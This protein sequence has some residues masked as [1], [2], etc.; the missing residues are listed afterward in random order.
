MS[1]T[2]AGSEH[3]N[4]P[5]TAS[6]VASVNS[7]TQIIPKETLTELGGIGDELQWSEQ[8]PDQPGIPSGFQQLSNV[9]FLDVR[10]TL[11]SREKCCGAG[12]NWN[13]LNG[14]GELVYTVSEDT[15]MFCRHLCGPHRSMFLSVMNEKG[16]IVALFVKPWRC[17]AGWVPC[18]M[19]KIMLQTPEDHHLG[20]V[21]QRFSCGDAIMDIKD[22]NDETAFQIKGGPTFAFRCSTS[23]LYGIYAEESDGAEG[24]IQKYNNPV[25]EE[26]PLNMS[27]EDFM[28]R[29]PE[30]A[31]EKE[32]MLIIGAA[33]QLNFMY[34][35]IT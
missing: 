13:L 10:T 35:E 9:D 25:L 19:Q 20:W 4:R 22:E 31:T 1:A 14:V 3:S 15:T 24:E 7:T 17:D 26:Y 12:M 6:S 28:I 18:W 34:F 5:E 23:L 8:L 16:K 27:H 33:F 21:R 32:K 29:F 30:E 11:D 2:H